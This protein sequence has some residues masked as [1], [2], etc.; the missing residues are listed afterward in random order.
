MLR[1]AFR[2]LRNFIIGP[3]LEI[4]LYQE[5]WLFQWTVIPEWRSSEGWHFT[6]VSMTFC[7]FSRRL[8]LAWVDNN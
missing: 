4:R 1:E 3:H 5:P 8:R 6:E 7:F 2:R